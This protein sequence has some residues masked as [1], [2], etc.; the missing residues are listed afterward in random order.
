MSDKKMSIVDN[1][2]GGID[3]MIDR[4]GGNLIRV[5]TGNRSLDIWRRLRD[6][7]DEAIS[8]LEERKDANST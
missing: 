1:G 8:N 7:C 6:L 2:V 4:D 5:L 3:L